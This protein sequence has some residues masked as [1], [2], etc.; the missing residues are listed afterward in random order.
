M[1]RTEAGMPTARFV[2]MIGV[3]ERSYRRWQA[4]AR[5]NRPPKGPWPQ[6]ARTAV[7]DAVVAHAKAHPAWDTGRSGR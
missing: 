5:A 1:I 3:P 2:D 4:K 7:R 6:P